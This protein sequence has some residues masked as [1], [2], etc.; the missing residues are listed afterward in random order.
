MLGTGRS[1]TGSWGTGTPR[2]GKRAGDEERWH[3][4][5]GL[6]ESCHWSPRPKVKRSRHTYPLVVIHY[7]ARGA[8]GEGGSGARTLTQGQALLGFWPRDAHF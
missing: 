6:V 7:N 5:V 8:N 4:W 1:H 3:I 2:G